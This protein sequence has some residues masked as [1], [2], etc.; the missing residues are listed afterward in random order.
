MDDT[1]FFI[2]RRWKASPRSV[3]R[4]LTTPEHRGQWLGSGDEHAIV[5]AE[6]DE[7][8]AAR[9]HIVMNGHDGEPPVTIEL[10]RAGDGSELLLRQDGFSEK[11]ACDRAE[12]AWKSHI[13]RLARHIDAT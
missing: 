9:Y 12:K 1:A 5:H 4:A 8:D 11:A 7:R 3:W 2:L 6:A 13:R 10:A